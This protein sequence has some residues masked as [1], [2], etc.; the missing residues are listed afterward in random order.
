LPATVEIRQ[1]RRGGSFPRYP[2][3]CGEDR[4]A[5]S[6]ECCKQGGCTGGKKE[7]GRKESFN[8]SAEIRLKEKEKNG[9]YVVE[10]QNTTRGGSTYTYSYSDV[11]GEQAKSFTSRSRQGE[12][13]RRREF[14][15]PQQRKEVCR[16]SQLGRGKEP[17]EGGGGESFL[18]IEGN[19]E[20]RGTRISAD[21]FYLLV[22]VTR[23]GGKKKGPVVPRP[24]QQKGGRFFE[25]G[26]GI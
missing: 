16:K 23:G 22:T 7:K 6:R 1:E 20:W 5:I 9:P 25:R 12:A 15:C 18:R 14:F 10:N 3:L 21:T 17:I 11:E 13:S 2:R 24:P 19:A 8:H 26:G 4:I